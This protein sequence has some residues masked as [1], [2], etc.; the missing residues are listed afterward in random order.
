MLHAFRNRDSL[1]LLLFIS[2]IDLVGVEQLFILLI[3]ISDGNK[4]CRVTYCLTYNTEINSMLF[5]RLRESNDN[6][7]QSDCWNISTKTKY[8]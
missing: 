2:I 8:S 1:D 7:I 3:Y 6:Q 4:K 5:I